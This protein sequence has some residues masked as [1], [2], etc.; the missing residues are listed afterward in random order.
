MVVNGSGVDE[1]AVHDVTN[2]AHLEEG[3]ISEYQLTPQQMGVKTHS[4]N[5]L[6]GSGPKSNA[7]KIKQLFD[8][9]GEEAFIDAVAVNAAAVLMLAGKVAAMTEGVVLAKQAIS[10][11]DAK[12][13]LE[14]LVATQ[15]SNSIE[16]PLQDSIQQKGAL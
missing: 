2:V 16:K 12:Q 6:Q 15:F 14:S 7:E 8:G 5:A 4:L 11:G 10:N 13:V 1:I 3:I 9:A